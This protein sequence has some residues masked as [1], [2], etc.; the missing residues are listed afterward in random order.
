MEN[1]IKIAVKEK[2]MILPVESLNEFQPK[3]FKELDKGEH[4]KLAKE[5]LDTGF[6]FVLSVWKNPADSKWYIIDGHQRVRTI[7][8]LIESGMK[9]TGLPC[10]QIEAKDFKAAKRRILQSTSQYG[11]MTSQGLYEL[12]NE[13]DL[14]FEEVSLSFRLPEINMP[15]FE[16]EFFKDPITSEGATELSEDD[17]SSLPNKCP[18][19]GFEF[20]KSAKSTVENS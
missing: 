4:E 16:V 3:E 7:K 19:C 20:E 5:I 10:V 18:R 11:R 6:A 2:L 17:F 8:R 15:T 14:N 1:E 12:M 9:C 13:A